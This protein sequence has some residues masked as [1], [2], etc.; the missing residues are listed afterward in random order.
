MENNVPFIKGTLAMTLPDAANPNSANGSFFIL[1]ENERGLK[2]SYAAFG[3]LTD[4]DS[5]EL[6]D[7]IYKDMKN[8]GAAPKITAITVHASHD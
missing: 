8:S 1:G 3:R 4:E 5:M 2:G 7:K 6:L